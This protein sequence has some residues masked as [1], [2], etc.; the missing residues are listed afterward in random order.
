MLQAQPAASRVLLTRTKM[1]RAQLRASH[2]I[3]A[4]LLVSNTQPA[5]EIPREAVSHVQLASIAQVW[6]PCLGGTIRAA[7]HVHWVVIPLQG[8]LPA[9]SVMA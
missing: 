6:G 9:L 1:T 4:A 8:S 2:V 7:W 5:L 3:I